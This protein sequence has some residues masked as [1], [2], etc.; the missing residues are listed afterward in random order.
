MSKIYL[1]KIPVLSSETDCL[2]SCSALQMLFFESP[3]KSLKIFRIEIHEFS[4]YATNC[5][6]SDVSKS[7][8]QP[9]QVGF[10]TGSL[11]YKP[12]QRRPN[13]ISVFVQLCICVC[14]LQLHCLHWQLHVLVVRDEFYGLLSLVNTALAKNNT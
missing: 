14:V 12:I 3:K 1:N 5:D 10:Y 11:T 8:F 4:I 13:F 2:H 9:G 7:I 6:K